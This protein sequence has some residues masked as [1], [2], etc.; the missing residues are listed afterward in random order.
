MD[1]EYMARILKEFEVQRQFDQI[2]HPSNTKFGFF[3]A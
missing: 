2:R 1:D 3:S